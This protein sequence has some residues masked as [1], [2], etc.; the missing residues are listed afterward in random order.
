MGR[1]LFAKLHI[2]IDLSMVL[3]YIDKHIFICLVGCLKIAISL[4]FTPTGDHFA[5]TKIQK[6][7]VPTIPTTR[8]SV[9]VVT[10]DAR[11]LLVKHRKGSRQYWVLPG[12]RLEY[13]ETFEECAVRELKE[14]TGLDVAVKEIVFLS[15]AIAP[16]RSRH[17]VNVYMTADVVGGVLKVGDEPVLAAVDYIPLAEL[18]KLSLFPPVGKIVIDTLPKVGKG[19][20]KFLGNLW[21]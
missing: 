2:A 14:E 4:D 19:C 20:I 12:G 18:D 10:E 17:I 15:E 3:S 7:P 13:G 21:V 9:I 5:K 11:I 16:D 8:I 6:R 1:L